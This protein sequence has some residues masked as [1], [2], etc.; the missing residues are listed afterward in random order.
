MKLL[1]LVP[2]S[3]LAACADPAETCSSYGFQAGTEAYANCQLQVSR[4]NSERAARMA[5]AL[6]GMT[7]QDQPST[8]RLSTRCIRNAYGFTC[9]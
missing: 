6:D 5:K 8:Q 4:D 9:N 7:L 3:L 1:M 2:I